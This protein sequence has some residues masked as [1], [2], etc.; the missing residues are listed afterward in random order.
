MAKGWTME[1]QV[2]FL[3]RNIQTLNILPL[4]FLAKDL[5]QQQLTDRIIARIHR[6]LTYLTQVNFTHFH[7]NGI[8]N[9]VSI[10]PK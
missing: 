3:E 5:R 2:H 9:C 6:A 1:M 7:L 8:N 4:P 10:M